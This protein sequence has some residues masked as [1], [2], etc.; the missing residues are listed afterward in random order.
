MAPSSHQ[1]VLLAEVIHYLNPQPNQNFVDATVGMGGHAR[2]ILER[3]APAGKLLALDWDPDAIAQAQEN[4]RQFESRIIFVNKNYNQLK[5]VVYEYQFSKISGIVCDLGYSSTQVEDGERGFS[6][7]S[8]GILD[9]RYSPTT[10]LTAD[11]ILHH[12]SE[13]QLKK[14]FKELGE[15]RLAGRIARAIVRK[16][17]EEK[18]TG[19]VLSKLVGEIY[20]QYFKKPSKLHPATKVWQALR[21]EVNKELDSLSAF[22]PQAV[23]V[24]EPGGRMAVISFHS[25]ED[26]IVKKFFKQEATDCL[27]DKRLP[28][29]ICQHRAQLKIITKKPVV[30]SVEE[31]EQNPRARSAKLRVAE[32]LEV[33]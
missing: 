19:E 17:K 28:Q 1:P 2:A 25:L 12:F 21:L 13:E 27:C 18:I 24:L 4:L 32:K 5:E 7:L 15:E 6:F 22:L 20:K 33:K 31:I 8:K 16:R 11:Y 14:I 10:E 23:S 29:C 9:L 30:P 26:R 3:T